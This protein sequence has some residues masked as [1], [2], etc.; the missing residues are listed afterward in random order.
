[1]VDWV[2]GVCGGLLIVVGLLD[3][4][5]TVLHPEDLGFISNRLYRWM[6]AVIRRTTALLPKG[7]RSLGRSLGGPLMILATPLMWIGLEI[8]GFTL[9][10]FVGM[11]GE[12]FAFAPKLEPDFLAAVYYSV[13]TVATL[14]YGDITPVVPFYQMLA[15]L[16]TL[17]G[18]GILSLATTYVLGV[19][20]VLGRMDILEM[21]L[22][23]QTED[24]DQPLSALERHFPEGEARE[25]GPLLRDFHQGIE[26]YHA[27][28]RRHPAVYFFYNRQPYRSAPFVFRM[29]SHIAAG[30]RWGL[31]AGHP[32]TQEP[33]LHPLIAGFDLITTLIEGRL[34]ISIDKTSPEPV[35]FT[36][37]EAALTGEKETEDRWLGHF[38]EVEQFMRRL[39]CLEQLPD[40]KEAYARYKEWLPFAYHTDSFVELLAKDLGYELDDLRR[41]PGQLLS[42]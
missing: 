16:G 23:H 5:L 19:Y 29:I 36:L 22:F 34:A 42:D 21:G 37:F 38:I 17:I 41:H 25:L 39:A 10:F 9:L 6:W 1:M 14:G 35:S 20:R 12:N 4:F 24:A 26:A 15:S 2:L 18:F 31:P 27:G 13:V 3:L 33:A 8:A 28:I 11:D 7:M 40:P 32:A 30:L